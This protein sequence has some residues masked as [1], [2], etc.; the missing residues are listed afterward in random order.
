[1]KEQAMNQHGADMA[2]TSATDA[3]TADQLNAAL[4][5]V[6]TGIKRALAPYLASRTPVTSAQWRSLVAR[7]SALRGIAVRYWRNRVIGWAIPRQRRKML[8]EE[9]YGQIWSNAD[10]A[11]ICEPT[12]KQMPHQWR[13][14]GFVLN[15]SVTQK[16]HLD[17]MTRAIRLV[18]PS[19]VLEVGSGWGL[20]LLVLGCQCPETR[21]Q[22][23]ELTESGVGL[24]KSLAAADE[25]PAP[26]LELM[27][28][29]PRDRA[30]Y[31]RI[32]VDRG[33]AE[34]L[35]YPDNS[36]DLV[37][38]RLAL[39][40]MESIR[41]TAI[42]EIARVARSH[43]LMVESFRELNDDGL[44]RRYAIANDYFRGRLADLPRYG[45]EP[46]F[47]FSDWP[48]KVTLKPVFVLAKKTARQGTGLRG[49]ETG[50]TP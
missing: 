47:T 17:L 27:S 48:H 25:L 26:V 49:P 36:F 32:A 38:T 6:E 34:N 12:K 40:Q 37:M 5:Q 22:G 19:T 18:R 1:V 10:L 46:V 23:I 8:V 24:A 3:S 50:A 44:R 20:N 28:E 7:E 31:R 35:P 30:G 39:E 2:G 42:A 13:Q 9:N 14:D 29:P 41:D 15:S 16:V 21:F 4:P 33:T 11:E 43:V 45:L